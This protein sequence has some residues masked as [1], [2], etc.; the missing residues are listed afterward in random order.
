M[1]Y[2][3]AASFNSMWRVF[4]A[5]ALP[6]LLVV[7]ALVFILAVATEILVDDVLQPHT[8]YQYLVLSALVSGLAAV[9]VAVPTV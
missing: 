9:L 3:G 2:N 4:E 7:V 5:R 6:T 1:L 8:M